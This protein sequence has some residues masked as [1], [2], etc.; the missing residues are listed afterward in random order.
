MV[1]AAEHFVFSPGFVAAARAALARRRADPLRRRDGGAWRH[2]RPAAGRQRGDLHAA[3]PADAGARQADRQHALGGGA[4]AL[5]RA[6]GRRGGRHRQ[7]ADG[8]LPPAGNAR[9]TARR[10]R[11]RSSAC[12]S[13]S[14]A[15]PNRRRRWPKS[16]HGMPFAIVRGP[17][18]RQRHDGGRRQRAGEA[19]PLNA[20]PADRR[21]HRAGRPGAPDAEGRARA[22]RGRCGRAFRQA[23]QQRQCARDRR[24]LP[25][26]RRDRTAADLSGDHRD[27]RQRAGDY[28]PRIADF[29]DMRRDRGRERI[30]RPG[31]RSRCCAR[32]TRCS[33]AP[34]CT[35]M[36][37]SRTAS[38]PRSSPASP[39][40]RAAGRRPACRSCRATTC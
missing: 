6:P 35:C 26:A 11:R 7:R 28:R 24:G 25:A 27:R 16:G 14:S 15:R 23:R 17:A 4:R 3:R 36:C 32:A 5:G 37:G 31:A 13:A 18:G 12:R 39:P 10:S 29:Y 8:A 20:R 9:A 2:P 22:R 34:T 21:R 1:E 33:T 38:R 30:W 40:C 19:G